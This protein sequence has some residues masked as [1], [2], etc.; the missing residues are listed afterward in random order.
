MNFVDFKAGA[1]DSGRRLDKVVKSILKNTPSAN[2]FSAIRKKLIKLNGAKSEISAH[3][4]ENDTIS[5]AEFLIEQDRNLSGEEPAKS[6][7]TESRQN[8]FSD[9]SIHFDIVFKNKHIMFINKPA[10]INVQPSQTSKESIAQSVKDEWQKYGD[11]SS[12][13]FTPAPLHRLDKYTS[14]LLA[15]SQDL[16]GARWFSKAIQDHTVQKTYA[17]IVCGSITECSTWKNSID[18]HTQSSSKD[19]LQYMHDNRSTNSQNRYHTVIAGNSDENIA[20]THVTPVTHGSYS[21]ITLSLVLFAIETGRKHQ[22]RAQSAIHGHP[23]F[24]DKI[25]G[26]LEVPSN[27]RNCHFFL[28]ALKISTPKSNPLEIPEILTA[29]FPDDFVQFTKK[30]F[31]NFNLAKLL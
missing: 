4:N 31:P 1:N 13:S 12:L 7:Q 14:G 9:S 30:A 18:T 25:Y 24:Q 3:L 22:I 16:N 17:G 11:K 5:I 27:S 26:G 6:A 10:G 21:G 28:H 8:T 2:V 23:L 20:I 29:P 15:I 19:S